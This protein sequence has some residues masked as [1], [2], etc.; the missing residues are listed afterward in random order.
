MPTS[1]YATL[2]F[3]DA[4][5]RPFWSFQATTVLDTCSTID[6][7]TPCPSE[8]YR[9]VSYF[10]HRFAQPRCCCAREGAIA[11]M[12]IDGVDTEVA[13]PVVN[14]GVDNSSS[15]TNSNG[16]TSVRCEECEDRRSVLDCGGC[17]GVF[18]DVCFY[19]LHRKGKRALHKPARIAR[20]GAT[21]TVGAGGGSGESSRGGLLNGWIGPRLPPKEEVNPD[22]YDR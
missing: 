3:C 18:C 15:G 22:M 2:G 9:G 6:S 4:V 12:E 5:G 13:S 19:A 11:A 16:E 1:S 20:P 21:A 8:A 7:L 10:L 17:G 14:G